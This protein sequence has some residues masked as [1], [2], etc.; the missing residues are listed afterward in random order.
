MAEEEGDKR[1]HELKT[2]RRDYTGY[3]DDEFAADAVAGVR[4]GVLSKYD[5]DI[6]GPS[7][8]VS[9]APQGTLFLSFERD[10][11][12]S[13]SPSFRRN[14]VWVAPPT[15][16]RRRTRMIREALRQSISY[17]YR[18]TMLVSCFYRKIRLPYNSV[19]FFS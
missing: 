9:A 1:R 8:T 12:S 15:K 10:W 6:E 13:K 11:R 17:Y 4:R 18:L 19:Q 2:K 16:L 7:Q 14:F 3:D 5:E